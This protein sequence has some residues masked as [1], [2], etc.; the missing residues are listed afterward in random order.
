M[1]HENKFGSS[2]EYSD[3]AISQG[4]GY[5]SNEEKRLDILTTEE[6]LDFLSVPYSFYKNNSKLFESARLRISGKVVRGR[7]DRSKL[8]ELTLSQP[9]Q[10]CSLKFEKSEVSKGTAR[11]AQ[12]RPKRYCV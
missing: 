1:K 6:M 5:K 7:F 9:N 12:R 8:I 4:S 10:T 2:E 3:D 11:P